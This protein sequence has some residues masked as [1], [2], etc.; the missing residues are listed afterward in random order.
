MVDETTRLQVVK[1]IQLHHARL[2]Y[3]ITDLYQRELILED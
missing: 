2:L 1:S 3:L